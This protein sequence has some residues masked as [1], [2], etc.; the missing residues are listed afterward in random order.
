V[1]DAAVVLA[2]LWSDR[3]RPFLWRPKSAQVKQ[4]YLLHRHMVE[5]GPYRQI[6]RCNLMSAFGVLRKSRNITVTALAQ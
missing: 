3:H 4:A 5:S 1:H 2:H 6:L